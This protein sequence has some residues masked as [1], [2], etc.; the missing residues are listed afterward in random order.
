LKS[1]AELV[2]GFRRRSGIDMY[3]RRKQAADGWND[4]AGSRIG[5][6]SRVI[7][8]VRGELRISADHPAVAM[9]IRSCHDHLLAALNDA[10]GADVFDRIAVV[11]RRR[12]TSR[13]P[14][15]RS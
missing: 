11:R 3:G 7:G 6:H 12:P 2:D 4:I 10:A 5:S 13:R 8:F 9:E 14:T 15:A 1:M